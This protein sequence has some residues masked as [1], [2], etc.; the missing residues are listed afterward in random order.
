[1][2]QNYIDDW[3][4]WQEEFSF[5][6]PVHVRFSD[7]DMNGHLSN[8]VAAVY[9]EYARIEFI[10]HL[11]V[12]GDWLSTDSDVMAVIADLQVDFMRQVYFDEQLTIHVKVESIGKSSADVH[13]LAVNEKGEACLTARSALVQASKSTG[14]SVAWSEKERSLLGHGTFEKA[15]TR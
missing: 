9:F 7:T 2:R 1:M 5:S 11:G 13:Y 8:T 10:K 6:I 3:E 14:R 4:R 15:N 12:G